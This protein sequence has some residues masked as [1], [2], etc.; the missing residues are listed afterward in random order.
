MKLVELLKLP[1]K[2]TD[3]DV[4]QAVT[5]LQSTITRL[6]TEIDAAKSQVRD[7]RGITTDEAD[8]PFILERIRA[9]LTR[10]QAVQVLLTHC[11]QAAPSAPLK[12][13]ETDTRRE[14]ET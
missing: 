4:C 9:G 12:H 8:E 5:A 7:L 11:A 14:Y 6:Q 2:A 10:A 3:D 1:A 13:N